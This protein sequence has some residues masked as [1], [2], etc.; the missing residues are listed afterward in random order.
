[1]NLVLQDM[2]AW[3]AEDPANRYSDSATYP[4]SG[5]GTGLTVRLF[6]LI[7]DEFGQRITLHSVTERGVLAEAT[8]VV[9]T[10]LMRWRA[11]KYDEVTAP[12]VA[13]TLG[14]SG[15]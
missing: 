9:T 11:G 12:T 4:D 8:R 1:M 2:I 13:A 10:A 3:H 14:A 5:E 6:A 15:S 7:T